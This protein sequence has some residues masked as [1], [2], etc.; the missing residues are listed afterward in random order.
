MRPRHDR[1]VGFRL[2]LLVER[3]RHLNT[4]RPP[5]SEAGAE[6]LLD[7]T[8]GSRV[9]RA[10]R[11]ADDEVAAE[12]LEMLSGLEDPQIDQAIVFDPGPASHALG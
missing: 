4:H 9:K 1:H 2:R 5:R 10:L 8:H 3:D 12:Q 6:R 7:Q 11:L